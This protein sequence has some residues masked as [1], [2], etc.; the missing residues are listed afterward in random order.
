M[1]ALHWASHENQIDMVRLLLSHGANIDLL[2]ADGI[3]P[4]YSATNGGHL[5][6]VRLL[7]EAGSDINF[8]GGDNDM[9]PLMLAASSSFE[10]ILSFLLDKGAN[11]HAR[12]INGSTA[13]DW[14]RNSIRPAAVQMLEEALQKRERER[15]RSMITE[16]S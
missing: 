13:L 3:I 5:E 14:A 7:L 8:H 1:S 15:E 10:N 4:L 9:T 6:V 16:N 12:D 11:I 2:G